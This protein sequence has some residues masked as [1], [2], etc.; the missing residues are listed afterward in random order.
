[1]LLIDTGIFQRILKLDISE[2]LFAEEFNLVNKGAIAEQFTGLEL[3]KYSSPYSQEGLFYWHREALNSN[4][5]ID[6]LVSVY[7]VGHWL[8]SLKFSGHPDYSGW[9]ENFNV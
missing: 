6:Y 3:I 7:K 2:L 9:P 4:A 1:M 5:E 8:F